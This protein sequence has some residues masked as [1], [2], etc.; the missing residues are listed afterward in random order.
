M[1][2]GHLGDHAHLAAPL[3]RKFGALVEN[4]DAVDHTS[5]DK[6]ELLVGVSREL[7]KAV[8]Q[9]PGADGVPPRN[10]LQLGRIFFF[11]PFKSGKEFIYAADFRAEFGGVALVACGLAE[12]VEKLLALFE[13]SLPLVG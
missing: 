6:E 5:G 2:R 8:V 4:V 1:G 3:V 7:L 12:A 9:E 13:Q 10:G 11:N